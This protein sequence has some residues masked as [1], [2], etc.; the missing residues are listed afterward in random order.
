M[1]LAL[2]DGRVGIIHYTLKNDDGEVLDS[3]V[4]YEPMAYLHGFHNIVPGL[5]NALVGKTTGDTL[6]V[7]VPPEDGYGEKQGEGPQRIRR[8]DLPRDLEPEVGMPLSG[9]DDDGNQF[10]LWVTEVKGAWVWVDINHPLAGET[11]H[12]EVEV[13]GVRDALDV[14]K[15]HGHAHGLDGRGHHHGH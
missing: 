6:E 2:A 9:E 13:V 15:Q 4:G 12:F 3:S 5:E 14:E 10:T 8:R 11:L 7:S 1:S